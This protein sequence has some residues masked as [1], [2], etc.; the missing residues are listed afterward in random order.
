MIPLDKHRTL[1]VR[2]GLAHWEVKA[3][4]DGEHKWKTTAIPLT[5]PEKMAIDVVAQWY[6]GERPMTEELDILVRKDSPGKPS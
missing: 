3:L 2:R 1:E 5:I 4:E 6:M